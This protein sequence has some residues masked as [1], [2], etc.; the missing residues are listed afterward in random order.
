MTVLA[1]VG[2]FLLPDIFYILMGILG[3]GGMI[4]LGF[5]IRYKW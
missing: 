3:G 4:A 1:L 2:Y 5:Y